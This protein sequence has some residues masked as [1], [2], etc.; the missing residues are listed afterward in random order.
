MSN[1]E[2]TTK[3]ASFNN[4]SSRVYGTPTI[5]ELQRRVEF[6]RQ[7]KMKKRNRKKS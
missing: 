5:D 6:R 7:E 2:I 4:N 3:N 1:T